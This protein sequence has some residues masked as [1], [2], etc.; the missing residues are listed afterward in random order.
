MLRLSLWDFLP[1]FSDLAKWMEG[2][3]GEVETA[4]PRGAGMRGGGPTTARGRILSPCGPA[5]LTDL[6][7]P[8]LY[9]SRW[10]GWVVGAPKGERRKV[11]DGASRQLETWAYSFP[12]S[13]LLPRRV[14][15]GTRK[16]RVWAR[17]CVLGYVCK[18]GRALI[19]VEHTE[20]TN[21]GPNRV[22]CQRL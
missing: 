9:S 7:L 22:R 1:L 13:H 21:G 20:E 19:P 3:G 8:H 6:Q 17:P 10:E 5:H 14:I 11:C 4:R 12:R 18:M 16:I 2:E 15:P